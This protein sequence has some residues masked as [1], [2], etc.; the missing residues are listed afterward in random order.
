MTRPLHPERPTTPPTKA[1]QRYIQELESQ[2][3]AARAAQRLAEQQTL[4]EFSHPGRPQPET[5]V[6]AL[7]GGTGLRGDF[8]P[9][10][11]GTEIEWRNLFPDEPHGTELAARINGGYNQ[12]ANKDW[13]EIS[14]DTSLLVKPAGSNRILI[15]AEGYRR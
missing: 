13:L 7:P 11:P 1:W 8:Q 9:L 15:R 4:A 3:A 12:A 10:A 5:K 6:Y 2:L 14:A